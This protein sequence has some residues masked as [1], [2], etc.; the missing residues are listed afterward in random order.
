MQTGYLSMA[1][2]HSAGRAAAAVTEGTRHS[3]HLKR[4]FGKV[5]VAYAVRFRGDD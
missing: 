4:C 2:R 5:P 3:R 1:G